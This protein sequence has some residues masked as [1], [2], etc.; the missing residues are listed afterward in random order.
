MKIINKY[1]GRNVTKEMIALLAG[2]ITTDE[3]N[4][5]TL[6]PNKC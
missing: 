4:L 6:T 1:T 2:I 5:I 3:F